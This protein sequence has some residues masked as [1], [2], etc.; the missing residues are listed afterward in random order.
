[1]FAH[2]LIFAECFLFG[3]AL[4][5]KFTLQSQKTNHR[6]LAIHHPR[7]LAL[8]VIVMNDNKKQEIILYHDWNFILSTIHQY[9]MKKDKCSHQINK[10][11]NEWQHDYPCIQFQFEYN[12]SNNKQYKNNTYLY[13]YSVLIHKL[14]KITM[15]QYNQPNILKKLP[16]DLIQY[17]SGEFM[18]VDTLI[19]WSDFVCKSLWSFYAKRPRRLTWLEKMPSDAMKLAKWSGADGITIH[20]D[21]TPNI[22]FL[23]QGLKFHKT[24]KLLI[25]SKKN[26]SKILSTSFLQS[27]ILSSS[28]KLSAIK[29]LIIYKVTICLDG[30]LNNI[31]THLIKLESLKLTKIYYHCAL[32]EQ[33]VAHYT[34]SLKEKN[35]PKRF[36]SL[37]FLTIASNTDQS[38]DDFS[39]YQI[40]LNDTNIKNNI[41]SLIVFPGELLNRCI[42]SV[43][44]EQQKKMLFNN[45]QNLHIYEM[46]HFTDAKQDH[47][48]ATRN[49]IYDDLQFVDTLPC[50]RNLL[51]KQIN[52]N[53]HYVEPIHLMKMAEIVII[54][55]STIKTI[56]IHLLLKDTE[57]LLNTLSLSFKNRHWKKQRI[58]VDITCE[59]P[60]PYSTTPVSFTK[61][62]QQTNKFDKLVKEINCINSANVTISY[63][64][65]S[66]DK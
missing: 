45:L 66:S 43:R 15:I 49:F 21:I 56:T 6:H 7:H 31:G 4:T 50:L 26:K 38:N 41:R 12:M 63:D 58:C 19:I 23:F 51:I 62:S 61:I 14:S 25:T 10:T 39:L 60:S 65:S 32:N 33:H 28:F 48:T 34:S 59:M 20:L 52:V 35:P 46:D 47:F 44:N 16:H 53:N 57:L 8:S 18:D 30:L 54:K 22:N 24:T 40:L 5:Q 37:H 17:I 42:D 29:N 36:Q 27:S 64:K 13:A 2:Y 9:T 3:F 55:K 1:M 11:I